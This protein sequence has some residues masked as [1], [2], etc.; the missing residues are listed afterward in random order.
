ME[1]RGPGII[2]TNRPRSGSFASLLDRIPRDAGALDAFLFAYSQLSKADRW[3]LVQAAL[4]DAANPAATL[5]VLL[6]AEED[7]TLRLRLETLL[8]SRAEIRASAGWLGTPLEGE[9]WLSQTIADR[10]ETLRVCWSAGEID[11]IAIEANDASGFDDTASSEHGDAI[12]VVTP[13]LWQH[14][15]RGRRLPEGVERF[16]G[17]FSAVRR[18]PT[19]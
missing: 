3:A 9:A 8:R 2:S 15:R 19:Q 17:F 7:Y 1:G 16:A 10:S 14:I 18:A 6:E 12:D 11:H 4:R 5:T 13:L